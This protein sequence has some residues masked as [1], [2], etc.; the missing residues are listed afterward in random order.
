MD[1]G[2]SIIVMF[3]IKMSPL[4]TCSFSRCYRDTDIFI[5]FA[6]HGKIQF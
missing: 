2:D 3:N 5:P 4:S 1:E 6:E